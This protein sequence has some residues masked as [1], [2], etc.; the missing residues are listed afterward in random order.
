M[1]PVA[2]ASTLPLCGV[3]WGVGDSGASIFPTE[4]QERCDG[5]E[6]QPL[7]LGKERDNV[8]GWW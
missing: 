7:M 3:P 5:D 6:L 2:T 8:E 4:V 1:Q